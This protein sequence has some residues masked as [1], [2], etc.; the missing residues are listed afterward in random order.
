MRIT[1][2]LKIQTLTPTHI[3]DIFYRKYKYFKDGEIWRELHT[4]T[5]PYKES[6]NKGNIADVRI[7]LLLHVRFI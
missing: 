3:L 6:V 4:L 1:T 5:I 7:T 2:F